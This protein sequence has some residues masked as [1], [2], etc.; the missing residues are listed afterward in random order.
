MGYYFDAYTSKSSAEKNDSTKFLGEHK[1]IVSAFEIAKVFGGMKDGDPACG[2]EL[3]FAE[4]RKI[5]TVII[6][7]IPYYDA[8][9]VRRNHNPLE[10]YERWKNLDLEFF[11]DI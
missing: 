5:V 2:L 1:S 3:T 8:D 9:D 10:K 11:R 6:P 4:V 7:N